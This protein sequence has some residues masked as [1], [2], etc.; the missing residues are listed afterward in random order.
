MFKQFAVVAEMLTTRE[1]YKTVAEH[2]SE[3]FKKT[4]FFFFINSYNTLFYIAFLKVQ[5]FNRMHVA[6][7]DS[8]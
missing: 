2:N 4:S 6:R 8:R 7:L 5:F 3:L 1:N